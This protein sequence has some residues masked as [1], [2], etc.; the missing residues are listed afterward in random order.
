[1]AD[2]SC[3]GTTPYKRLIDHQTRDASHHQDRLVNHSGGN[4]YGVCMDNPEF[5]GGLLLLTT[6]LVF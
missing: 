6:F 2:A 1:M 3:S 4:D 5:W